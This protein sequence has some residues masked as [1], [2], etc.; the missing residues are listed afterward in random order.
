MSILGD[1]VSSSG[2]KAIL[3]D[4]SWN[5]LFSIR[6]SLLHKVNTHRIER[7]RW[8][9][10]DYS[11]RLRIE[12]SIHVIWRFHVE[13]SGLCNET[14]HLPPPLH[15]KKRKIQH[16]LQ[17]SDIFISWF[18]SNTTGDMSTS[19]KIVNTTNKQKKKFFNKKKTFLVNSFMAMNIKKGI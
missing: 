18:Y 14:C 8:I 17:F 13:R 4:K 15:H 6:Q 7:R 10:S 12:T 5:N 11:S 16:L 9:K 19:R 1:L 3:V 2:V